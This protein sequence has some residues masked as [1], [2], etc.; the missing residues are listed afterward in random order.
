[1]PAL[2]LSTLPEVDIDRQLAV[3]P[4]LPI[5]QNVLVLGIA[6]VVFRREPRNRK[7]VLLMCS[8]GFN[9]GLFAFPIVG[10]IWGKEAVAILAIF[11]IGNALMLLGVNYA[12]GAYFSEGP[13]AVASGKTLSFVGKNLATS[14]PLIAFVVAILLNTSGL[15]LPTL[16]KEPLSILATANG[17]MVFLLL[18]MFQS[19]DLR[20]WEPRSLLRVF[21]VRYVPGLLAGIAIYLFSDFSE[22]VRKVLLIA[23][24]LPVGMSAIPFA[25]R[26]GLDHRMATTLINTTILFSFALIW[27]IVWIVG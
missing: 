24:A 14:P 1:L 25:V 21:A 6:M 15:V 16:V 22:L 10:A 4:L 7:G 19:F 13:D 20:S 3:I 5:L 18:G 23:F 11:D 8:I 12:I 9:N 27:V 17:G 2:V 26:F